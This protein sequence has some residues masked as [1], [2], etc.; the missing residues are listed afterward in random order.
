MTRVRVFRDSS[1]PL[2]IFGWGFAKYEESLLHF[3]TWRSNSRAYYERHCHLFF[4]KL[5]FHCGNDIFKGSR[6]LKKLPENLKNTDGYKALSMGIQSY[7]QNVCMTL[8]K[9]LTKQ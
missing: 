6:L 1:I 2:Q 9:A 8:R 5:E 7:P 4:V 3:V